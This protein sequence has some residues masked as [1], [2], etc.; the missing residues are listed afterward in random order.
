MQRPL[1]LGTRGSPLA[2]AQ[3]RLVASALRIAHDWH[4][5]AIAI[6]PIVTT[7]DVIQDRSLADLGGKMLWTRELDRALLEGRTDASVHSLKDVETIRPADFVIAAILPR[8]DARDRLVGVRSIAALPPGARVGT[9]S[10]R[11]AAQLRARRPDVE[12]VVLRGNVETRLAKLARG[13]V[14]ATL[15]AAAGLDRSGLEGIGA[16]IDDMLPAPS[17]GAIGVEMLAA[18]R[19]ARALVAA[20]DDPATHAC[21][22][23][24]RAFLRA[25][26]GDC[27][28]AVA[29]H[30]ILDDGGV[31]LRAE[32]LS[33]DG[34]EV[35]AGQTRCRPGDADAP[36]TLARALLDR[37]S[38]ALRALFAA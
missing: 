25:L 3:A 16:P 21:V 19:E 20:V 37:A 6:I 32:L 26:G 22:A 23:A 4:E 36:A 27:R 30:A 2:L 13:D 31:D 29:A 15:L 33:A 24:E 18:N 38:P 34:R 35:L 28:S 8:A 5:E 10:P 9:S 12:P 7:G 11:R 1:H 14:D 17:Q